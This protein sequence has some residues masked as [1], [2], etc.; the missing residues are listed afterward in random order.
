MAS[1]RKTNRI[2]WIIIILLLA[3]LVYMFV[4]S[5]KAVSERNESFTRGVEL[6]GELDKVMDEYTTIKMENQDLSAQ[7]SE[8][9]SIILANRAEIEK[10]IATQADYNKIRRKLDL[11]RKIT[12]DY[13]ARID[14]LVVVNQTLTEE[15]TQLAETVTQFKAQN[16]KLEADKSRLQEKVTMASAL[17]AYDLQ[18]FTVRVLPN[19]KEKGTDRAARVTRINL[20]FTVGENKVVEP[21]LKTIYARISRPDGQVMSLGTEDN[22]SFELNGQ[23]LQ[24]TLKQEIDYRNEAQDVKMFWDRKN[25]STPAMAGTYEVM[26]YAEGAEIGRASF[27]IRE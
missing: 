1:P 20:Q 10:L 14:S 23:T 21:G 13:V 24:Y 15:N 6:K 5:Q 7:M 3:A 19:G 12:Q 2:L 18:A 11:L 22:Y 26:L 8:K 17:K 16:N 27:M 25:V 9:D 4:R